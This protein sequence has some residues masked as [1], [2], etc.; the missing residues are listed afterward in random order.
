MPCLGQMDNFRECWWGKKKK[1]KG[2]NK[3]CFF[4]FSNEKE[5]LLTLIPWIA[6][7][8]STFIERT[9]VMLD[10]KYS[11]LTEARS[12]GQVAKGLKARPNLMDRISNYLWL[13][14]LTL[15]GVY[16]IRVFYVVDLKIEWLC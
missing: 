10:S 7:L 5:M 11:F 9:S 15:T 16:P 14:V 1:K 2:R 6:W 13:F 8:L 12:S 3:D 4:S